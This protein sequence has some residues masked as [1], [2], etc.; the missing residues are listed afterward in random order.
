ME[1]YVCDASSITDKK[2]EKYF[3]AVRKE[4]Q[5][6]ISKC[7]RD[8][9]KKLSLAA[10][11]ALKAALQNHDIDYDGAAFFIA[12]KGKPYLKGEEIPIYFNISHS[13]KY[14]VA[15]AAEQEIGIDIQ[16]IDNYSDRVVERCFTQKE[17]IMLEQA[18]E[19]KK[20]ETFTILWA[21]K[22]SYLKALGIGI[23]EEMNQFEADYNEAE[24]CGSIQQIAWSFGRAYKEANI[25]VL[26][27][28]KGYIISVCCFGEIEEVQWK[29][30]LGNN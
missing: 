11:L 28:I 2:F 3:A 23:T 10:G 12:E 24:G 29:K 4:R 13:G 25:K 19:E 5:N 7:K 14:A 8:A 15:V 6:K 27:N 26:K 22:E 16:R 17:K 20:K 21:M 1:I 18:P 9:D 30:E